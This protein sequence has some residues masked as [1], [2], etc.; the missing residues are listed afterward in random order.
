MAERLTNARPG[1]PHPSSAVKRVL[2][3]MIQP[4]GCSGVQGLIYNKLMPFYQEHGWEVHFAGPAPRLCSV[5]TEPLDYPPERLH[6]TTNVSLSRQWSIRK[7][8][9][10]KGS[11]PH[12]FHGVMQLLAR[13]LERLLGHDSD[14]YTLRGL[15][16]TVRAAEQRWTFDLI[17]GKSPDFQVLAL[18]HQLSREQGKPFL[19]L[20]DDPHGAR[21][22]QGFYPTTPERQRAILSEARGTLFMSPLTRERYVQAGL[23]DANKAHFISDSYP[24]AKDLYAADRSD[25]AAGHRGNSGS[26][27]LQLVYLGMLPEWRPIEPLLDALRACAHLD[28]PRNPPIQLAIHG[29]VYGR[30]RERIRCDPRLAAMIQLRPLVDYTTSHWLAE[31]TDVQLVVIGPRHLDNYPSKFFE[32]LG[33]R[34]P[35]LILGPPQNPLRHIVAELKIGLYVDGRRCEAIV[36]ALDTLR[37]DY[38]RFQLAYGTHGEAIAAYSAPRVA[39]RFC[40][41]LDQALAPPRR[42]PPSLKALE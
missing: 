24:V 27:P 19:A 39:Q 40:N 25:L 16:Q 29:F 12:L 4:P 36:A 26:R 7:N 30:A 3:V 33:H 41:L 17:A 28:G 37:A 13:T 5:L 10:A 15:A 11:L 22:E 8:R 18:V 2:L 1:D 31:D 42:E 35:L 21:D 20:L 14:A 23:V 38:D 34:K 32:Y 6:Y 9:H